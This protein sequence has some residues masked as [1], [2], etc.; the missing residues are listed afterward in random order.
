MQIPHYFLLGPK[1]TSWLS[2]SLCRLYFPTTLSTASLESE[3]GLCHVGNIKI[4]INI[5][6]ECVIPGSAGCADVL[7]RQGLYKER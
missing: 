5:S 1:F 2:E 3:V 6:G 4:E 7:T